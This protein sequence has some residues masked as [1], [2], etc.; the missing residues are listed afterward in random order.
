MIFI[1]GCAKD[2]IY[3]LAGAGNIA[4]VK[5]SKRKTDKKRRTDETVAQALFKDTPIYP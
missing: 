2:G 1:I 5:S 4:T 3:P